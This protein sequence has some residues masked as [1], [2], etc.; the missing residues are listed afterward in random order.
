MRESIHKYF[1][2]GLI[3]FLAYPAN[4]RGEDPNVAEVIKKVVRDDYFDAVELNWIKDAARRTE[5]KKLLETSHLTVCYGAQPRLL[6]TCLYANH[7]VEAEMQKEE[8]SLRE[9]IVEGEY[10]GA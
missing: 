5:V 2:V 6:T 3:S 4:L 8:A 10:L 9:A 1:K 7:L